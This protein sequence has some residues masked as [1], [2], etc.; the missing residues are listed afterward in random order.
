M[1][2]KHQNKEILKQNILR[3]CFNILRLFLFLITRKTKFWGIKKCPSVAIAGLQR[4]QAVGRTWLC[5]TGQCGP[6]LHD[7]DNEFKTDVENDPVYL[8]KKKWCW[9]RNRPQVFLHWGRFRSQG[10]FSITD[11]CLTLL[12]Q[13][14]KSI[15]MKVIETKFTYIKFY[16]S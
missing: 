10:M 14:S 2:K 6:P 3:D 15:Q 16:Y 9:G 11:Q 8:W 12:E 5:E 4:K 13:C 1:L 7:T